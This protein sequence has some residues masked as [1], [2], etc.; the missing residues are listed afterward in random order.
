M[1]QKVGKWICMII[2]NIIYE[3]LSPPWITTMDLEE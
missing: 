2:I 3:I 1:I